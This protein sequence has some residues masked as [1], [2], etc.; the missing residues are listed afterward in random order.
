M[1][2]AESL[3]TLDRHQNVN[4]AIFVGIVNAHFSAQ[5]TISFI[6]DDNYNAQ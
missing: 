5:I 3:A 1:S 2:A 6:G 4:A